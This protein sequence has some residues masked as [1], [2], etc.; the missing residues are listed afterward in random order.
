[1]PVKVQKRGEAYRIVEHNTKRLVRN[2]GGTPVDGK[3]HKSRAKA[4]RQADAINASLKR[5]GII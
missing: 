2:N 1:M 5:R 4:Q 3:G